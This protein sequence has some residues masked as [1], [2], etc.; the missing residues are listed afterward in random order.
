MVFVGG[1][2]LLPYSNRFFV[3]VLLSILLLS[4]TADSQT[5]NDSVVVPTDASTY[6]SFF[7]QVANNTLLPDPP[8]WRPVD[9]KPSKSFR[10]VVPRIED[11]IGLSDHEAGLVTSAAK[12][13]VSEAGGPKHVPFVFEARLQEM[14]GGRVSETVS[15]QVSE[16]E[17]RWREM[18]LAYVRQLRSDLGDARFQV[19]NDYVRSS[20][21]KTE[22]LPTREAR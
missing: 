10:I 2:V 17:N 3:A 14:E 16:L 12:G 21:W 4:T 7:R 18:V 8:E 11:V 13:Y 19:L 5:S 6:K 15:G 9:H 22:L 1:C 20:K